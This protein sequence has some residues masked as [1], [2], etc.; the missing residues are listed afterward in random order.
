[1]RGEQPR[2]EAPAEAVPQMR[3]RGELAVDLG[4]HRES[5]AERSLPDGGAEPLEETQ[6]VGPKRRTIRLV[7]DHPE[8]R[9]Q[10]EAASGERGL[11]FAAE[12]DRRREKLDLQ[13]VRTRGRC[14]VHRWL[15]H[16]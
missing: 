15:V 7:E 16:P 14:A 9:G 13:I 3:A 1:M 11:H 10:L 12:H 5:L 8:A 2:E 6:G 4:P